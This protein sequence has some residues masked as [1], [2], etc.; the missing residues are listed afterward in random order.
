MASANQKYEDKARASAKSEATRVSLGKLESK[1]ASVEYVER[2]NRVTGGAIT[3]CIVTMTNGF[4]VVDASA[5]A[6]PKNHNPVLG[7]EF[8][9]DRCVRQIWAHEGYLMREL[10]SAGPKKVR[11]AAKQLQRAVKKTT[12]PKPAPKK[13][14]VR[15]KKPTR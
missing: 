5:A 8:S 2:P 7:R 11:K 15:K 13:V 9:F 4:Q 12:L 10:L 14:V 1:I 3:I 6:D